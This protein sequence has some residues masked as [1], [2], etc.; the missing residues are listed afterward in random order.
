[1]ELGHLLGGTVGGLM[2]GL[3]MAAIA[4]LVGATLSPPLAHG[5]VGLIVGGVV[6]VGG[7]QRLEIGRRAQVPV[8]TISGGRLLWA[9]MAW[10]LTLGA[11]FLTHPVGALSVLALTTIAIG[12]PL[13][14]VLTFGAY[15][16]MRAA[17]HVFRLRIERQKLV[18][19]AAIFLLL[20]AL[21][22]DAVSSLS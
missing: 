9:G 8:A 21:A 22:L 13:V 20:V 2:T 15:G 18:N 12:S 5:L 11:G 10:G 1:M 4:G 14:S 16:A 3:L 17:S 7:V 6:T 19:V